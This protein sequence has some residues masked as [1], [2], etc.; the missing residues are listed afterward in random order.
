MFASPS[1]NV[2][3]WLERTE[4]FGIFA[5]VQAV[6]LMG[7]HCFGRCA[8][9]FKV[10]SSSCIREPVCVCRI[11]SA[12]LFFFQSIARFAVCG[13]SGAQMC[14]ENRR[15]GGGETCVTNGR[16]FA[17]KCAWKLRGICVENVRTQMLIN[18]MK[19]PYVFF[20]RFSRKFHGRVWRRFHGQISKI[21]RPD[22][23]AG[24]HGKF[25]TCTCMFRFMTM[26]GSVCVYMCVC[27]CRSVMEMQHICSSCSRLCPMCDTSF[28][29]VRVPC[30]DVHCVDE[31]DFKVTFC[32]MYCATVC[33]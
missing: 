11:L 15:N 20:T 6:R 14:R 13:Q 5:S 23:T 3:S 2:C 10:V 31:S 4:F 7:L 21:S 12:R 18:I 24:L 1:D 17:W 25:V 29:G 19:K 9:S 27:V 26:I 16:E 30:V 22:T 33:L 28:I 32:L 8:G